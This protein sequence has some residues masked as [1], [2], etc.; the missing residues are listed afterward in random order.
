MIERFVELAG[1][2]VGFIM[3]CFDW[4]TGRRH[5]WHEGREP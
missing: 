2:T 1:A 5:D 3:R 4:L